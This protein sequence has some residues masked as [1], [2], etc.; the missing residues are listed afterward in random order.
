VQQPVEFADVAVP[1]R[2]LEL[3][4]AASSA[5]VSSFSFTGPA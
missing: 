3:P 1:L 5:A 2:V 4:L